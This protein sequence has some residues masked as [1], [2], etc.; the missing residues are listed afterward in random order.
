V[1]NSVTHGSLTVRHRE[2]RPRGGADLIHFRAVTG[3][4]GPNIVWEGVCAN[5][6]PRF[7]VPQPDL[8][9]GSVDSRDSREFPGGVGRGGV[10]GTVGSKVTP[11]NPVFVGSEGRRLP[12]DTN[13]RSVL[14]L[15][16]SNWVR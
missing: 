5:T 16:S 11:P 10:M 12:Q 4:G 15:D 7:L 3:R 8:S 2:G 13:H 9:L 14:V 6:T 1:L